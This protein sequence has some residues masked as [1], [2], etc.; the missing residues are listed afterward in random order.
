M[1]TSTV[2]LP[3]RKIKQG[4][5]QSRDKKFYKMETTMTKKS[6]QKCLPSIQ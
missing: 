4:E 5:K 3:L 1:E 2:I 6:V